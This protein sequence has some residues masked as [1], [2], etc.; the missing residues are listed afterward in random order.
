VARRARG[1]LRI[2]WSLD[3]CNY[4]GGPVSAEFMKGGGRKKSG[5]GR[6]GGGGGLDWTRCGAWESWV[7]RGR[8]GGKTINKIRE[9][10]CGG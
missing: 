6:N 8:G 3:Q 10:G 1:G 9:G 5:N 7:G 4:T 2:R